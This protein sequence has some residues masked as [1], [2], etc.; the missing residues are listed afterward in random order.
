MRHVSHK[1]LVVGAALAVSGC[2]LLHPANQWRAHKVADESVLV[3]YVTGSRI[4]RVGPK[5]CR[6]VKRIELKQ[7]I[8]RA[9]GQQPGGVYVR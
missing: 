6:R 5:D 7:E 4:K 9:S 8:D 1:W 2:G 3:C